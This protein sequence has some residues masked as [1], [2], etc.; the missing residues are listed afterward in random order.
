ML[1]VS[2]STHTHTAWCRLVRWPL[3]DHQQCWMLNLPASVVWRRST[4]PPS[5]YGWW[6]PAG[7]L[8]RRDDRLAPPDWRHLE[9]SGESLTSLF[10]E[11]LC[12]WGG[13]RGG[14]QS[15]SPIW[16]PLPPSWILH[17][18]MLLSEAAATILSLSPCG[19][20]T[21][22]A[23]SATRSMV[24]GR[25][26]EENTCC[27]PEDSFILPPHQRALYF[28]DC[29]HFTG[30]KW[31]VWSISL[32]SVF[33][34][35]K[36]IGTVQTNELHQTIIILPFSFNISIHHRV[37]VLPVADDKVSISCYNPVVVS[38]NNQNLPGVHHRTYTH[39]HIH[40]NIS[41]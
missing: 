15:H 4:P 30:D 39:T 7:F 17:R 35:Q 21:T 23:F 9:Q 13:G 34:A 16:F 27:H 12:V 33:S 41:T 22:L 29:S 32:K 25:W 38:S 37:A 11:E 2:P 28:L 18:T 14:P 1:M 10:P 6:P 40:Y 5:P 26:G 8:W 20:P 24:Q 19:P 36:F 31:T 3:T